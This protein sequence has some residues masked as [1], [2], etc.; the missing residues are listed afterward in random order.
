MKVLTAARLTWSDVEVG[1]CNC[2]PGELVMLGDTCECECHGFGDEDCGCF[3]DCED[4]GCFV[5]L[6]SDEQTTTARIEE[7]DCSPERLSALIR[8]TLTRAGWLGQGL[9]PSIETALVELE[10]GR[11]ITVTG[12]FSA[13]TLIALS[14]GIAFEVSGSETSDRAALSPD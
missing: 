4:D 9:D 12:S 7:R 1:F 6:T 8:A 11:I 13:G 5:G 14:Q 10:V 3:L 2:Q